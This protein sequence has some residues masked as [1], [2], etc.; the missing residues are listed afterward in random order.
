MSQEPL[1]DTCRLGKAPALPPP[2]IPDHDLLRCI[3]R[4][5]YG[6]VW[7]ARNRMGL[8]R[9]VKVVFRKSF[10][11]QRPFE[12]EWS[13]ICK[14]EPISRSHEGFIDVLQVG[15]NEEQGYFY[16][17]MELGDDEKSA[18]N[19]DPHSYAPRTLGRELTLKGKRSFQECLQLGLALSQALAELHRHG[20]V[21]R[22]VKPSN[23]IFVNGVPKLADIGLVA[24][25]NAECSYVGTEGF[26]P[27]EGPGTPQADVYGLGKVLYEASTG[28]DRNDYPELPTLLDQQPDREKFLELNEVTLHA[29]RND[30]RERYASGWE[31][32]ADLL[33]LANGKSVK[34]LRLLE[35]RLGAIKRLG[36]ASL[37]AVL[38]LAAVSYQVYREWKNAFQARQRQVGTSVAVG[39]QAM[40]SGDLLDSLPHSAEALRLDHGNPSREATHR[41]RFGSTL[42]QCPKLTHLWAG[43]LGANDGEFSPDGKQIVIARFF[44]SAEVHSLDKG[45]LCGPPL[46]PLGAL[47]TASFSQDGRF[48][49]T[50]SQRGVA[51]FW[52]AVNLTEIRR[53]P[54]L[55][56]LR[57]VRLSPDG[58]RMIVA[59]DDAAQVWSTQTGQLELTLNQHTDE[60]HFADFSHNGRIIVTASNDKTAQLWDAADGRPLGRPLK[61]GSWVTY[62]AFSP[63]DQQVVT[64][65]LDRKARVWEVATGRQIPPDMVHKDGVQS[66]EF[67]PD[68]RLILTACWDGTA[69]L[70]RANDFQ[71]L[72]QNA[73]L[74]EGGRVT[75]AAFSPDGRCILIANEE[76]TVRIWDLAGESVLASARSSFSQD[77]SRCFTFTNG[78]VEV[79]DA[80]SAS[81]V[82]TITLAS[83]S[84]KPLA[85]N[86][87]ARFLLGASECQTNPAGSTR[88]FLVWDTLT[89]KALGPQLTISNVLAN[90]LLSD[91]GKRLA[92][93]D[94]KAAQTWD[95]PTGSPLSPVLTHDDS[96]ASVAFS[97][98]GNRIAA[99]SGNQ[100]YVWETV[101]GQPVFA[102]LMHPQ[103]ASHAEFS[104][105]GRFLVT[106][107]TD[108]RLTKCFSQVWD[109]ATGKPVGPQLRHGDGVLW[110]EFSP[111]SR[112]VVTASEDFTAMQW[113]VATGKPL[114][115]PLK[116]LDQVHAVTFSPDQKWIATASIDQTARIWDAGTGDPLTP[117]LSHLLPMSR[118]SFLP[119]G[120]HILTSTSL[121]DSWIWQ[122][123]AD[124]R[125]V[126]DLLSLA[127]LLS[128]SV[129]VAPVETGHRSSASLETTWRQL[130]A[131]YPAD[132]TVS[133]A[134]ITAWH[135]FQANESEQENQWFAAA[136]HLRQLLA[137]HPNDPTLAARLVRVQAQQGQ[138][139]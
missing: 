18:Q 104:P 30:F 110:A 101:G 86:R 96:V 81:A 85:L 120:S 127:W 52:D 121:G 7:L 124:P 130:R 21:H 41:L 90:A 39:I 88:V 128:G 59:G 102:P 73:V 65:S 23:I 105:D 60:L 46:K 125:P 138:S 71:P 109:A 10:T 11:D 24:K 48:I 137:L 95:V 49:V 112:R 115:P 8:Y 58:L 51:T 63:D 118:V 44:G 82:S 67:S 37:L 80:L 2:V 56:R 32:Y 9:A 57:T 84:V 68:G 83:G 77:G 117:P 1:D 53:F 89:G 100:V 28:K 126:E 38:V 136:F 5:S 74:P 22:D 34:R 26:I 97:R 17:V 122:L 66:A 33:V 42:A 36:G 123:A 55:G 76:G 114:T 119:D 50:A 19:I 133:P 54:D 3:G 70:W 139:N 99:L 16:Y 106:C 12:R 116:H 45:N 111:D 129:G 75:R 62:A 78:A 98:D 13:G 27:P 35:R 91:D 108:P 103:S 69:R 14:F 107:C 29:C 25:A 132:F 40:N 6:A 64:A 87:N 94:G 72:A 93:F 134:Q 15:L 43:G 4:G 113:D 92:T 47:L 79:R 31:M 131:K 61:H 135:E 20:L